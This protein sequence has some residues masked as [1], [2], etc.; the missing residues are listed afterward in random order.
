MT[1]RRII[2]APFLLVLVLFA[3][4]NTQRVRVGLWPTDYA[5]E[6]P[7][8]LTLL[9]AMATTF[10]IGAFMLWTSAFG[11]RR[12]A[13]RAQEALRLLEAQLAELKARPAAPPSHRTDLTVMPAIPSRPT[14]T[15]LADASGEAS[16]A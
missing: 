10:L 1:L 11:D 2:A 5:F 6:A 12:R 9:V 15:Q 8:S 3:L 13:A 14:Q 4:S 7:L 16:R